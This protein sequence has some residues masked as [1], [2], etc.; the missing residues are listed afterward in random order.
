[1]TELSVATVASGYE[2][3]L[4]LLDEFGRDDPSWRFQ[5]CVRDSDGT[6]IDAW[7]GED[8]DP[9]AI[10]AQAS[11]TKGIAGITV[12]LLVERGLLDLDQP[13]AELWPEFAAGGK[14]G[15]TVAEALSHQAGLVGFS[16]PFTIG[17]VGEGHRAAADLAAQRPRWTPGRAHGYHS[18]TIGVLADELV[19]RLTGRRL[20]DY[21]QS[22]LADPEGIDFW[23]RLPRSQQGRVVP[24]EVPA[25][26]KTVLTGS[27]ADDANEVLNGL[28]TGNRWLNSAALRDAGIASVSGVGSARGLAGAYAAAIGAGGS[29]AALSRNAIAEMSQLRTTGPDLVLGNDTRYAVLFQKPHPGLDFGTADAFGHDGAGGAL[30]FADPRTGIAFGYTTRRVPTPGGAARRAGARAPAIPRLRLGHRPRPSTR[31]SASRVGA[32]LGN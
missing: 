26:P 15:I 21:Y 10:H 7:R 17:E 31:W 5:L 2:P 18:L 28:G 13:L 27:L 16:R 24:I 4:D 11:T 32:A 29:Q 25:A 3:V 12:G 22:E 1:V 9:I 6:A 14:S 23:I 20:A 8:Y 30:G 19:S